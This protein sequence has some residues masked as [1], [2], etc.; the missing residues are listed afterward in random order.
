MTL[1]ESVVSRRRGYGTESITAG[2]A[3]IG[4]AY[5]NQGL[6]LTYV[7][8]HSEAQRAANL[9][10]SAACTAAGSNTYLVSALAKVF[11]ELSHNA[12]ASR[13]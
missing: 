11:R 9:F 3:V 12:S 1:P 4:N 13:W 6:R 2:A 5:F 10:G 7:F 8:N